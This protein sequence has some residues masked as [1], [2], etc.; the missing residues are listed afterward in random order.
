[1]TKRIEA[2]ELIKEA[3]DNK[4]DIEDITFQYHDHDVILSGG[5]SLLVERQPKVMKEILKSLEK[6]FNVSENIPVEYA[7]FNMDVSYTIM[8]VDDI[9]YIYFIAER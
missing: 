7:L 1:M 9:F 3:F 8:K 2:D 6:H 4:S 5:V